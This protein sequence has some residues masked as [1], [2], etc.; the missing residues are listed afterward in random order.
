MTRT[1]VS[2]NPSLVSDDDNNRDATGVVT[3]GRP[4]FPPGGSEDNDDDYDIV[5]LNLFPLSL[6]IE[7]WTHPP[8]WP[9]G[10]AAWV[11][12]STAG[13]ILHSN[14]AFVVSNTSSIMED[15][16]AHTVHYFIASS[17][18]PEHSRWR[19]SWGMT[20]II[21]YCT[22]SRVLHRGRCL[23]LAMKSGL[24]G[25]AEFFSPQSVVVMSTHS[26][27]W[28]HKTLEVHSPTVCPSCPLLCSL[29]LAGCSAGRT[30]TIQQA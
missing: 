14:T 2:S 6:S 30:C 8:M 1:V 23:W 27:Q 19:S 10:M 9:A 29:Q 24:W 11:S 28:C 13:R 3:E 5:R 16:A 25:S 21:V 15:S 22:G 12:E 4:V 17:Y 18:Q 26:V 20:C 7:M